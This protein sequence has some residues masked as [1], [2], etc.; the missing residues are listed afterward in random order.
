M[1]KVLAVVIAAIVAGGA[2]VARPPEEAV[3]AETLAGLV[4]AFAGFYAGWRVSLAVEGAF[5]NREAW[6]R[7]LG[8]GAVFGGIIVG[9][10]GGVAL[11]GILLGVEGNLP[12]CVLGGCLGLGVGA[13]LSVPIYALAGLDLDMLFVP[14]ATVALA[15][16]G[17]N[18][19][20]TSR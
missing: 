8:A 2:L 12:L 16:W 1:R 10:S 3:L 9:A 15:V 6:V 14:I 13:L 5:P 18:H 4:G 11:T 7:H 19:G 17:F 20:A